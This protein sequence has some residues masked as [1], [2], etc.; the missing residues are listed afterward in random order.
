M[1]MCFYLLKRKGRLEPTITTRDS[2]QKSAL[3]TEAIGESRA[4]DILTLVSEHSD[5]VAPALH[6][7][8]H[9]ACTCSVFGN[10]DSLD[11]F[12]WKEDGR[13]AI[14]VIK[15]LHADRNPSEMRFRAF[16]DTSDLDTVALPNNIISIEVKGHHLAWLDDL[17]AELSEN[18]A[19]AVE[20]FSP[21]DDNG[22]LRCIQEVDPSGLAKGDADGTPIDNEGL[23]LHRAETEECQD[24]ANIDKVV[25]VF[26]IFLSRL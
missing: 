18:V 4:H 20:K 10:W 21:D 6:L 23:R 3:Q 25:R 2:F 17:T 15:H 14:R 5:I 7:S 11:G 24:E 16:D 26:M 9:R 22:A 13:L 19:I 12:G 8:A 1:N